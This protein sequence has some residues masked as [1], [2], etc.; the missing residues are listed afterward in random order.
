MRI[1]VY[2]IY[3]GAPLFWEITVGRNILVKHGLEFRAQG[4]K[5]SN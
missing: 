2:W 4:L 3:V 1:I 5:T